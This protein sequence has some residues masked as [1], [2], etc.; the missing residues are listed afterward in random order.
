MYEVRDE[1]R[2]IRF[3]GELL[4]SSSS[5]NK[6][7]AR[8]VEFRLYKTNGG[9]YILS[10]IGVS[11]YYHQQSC[12]V[13]IRNNI[14]PVPAMNLSM[15]LVPCDDCRPDKY[16]DLELFPETP[17]YWAQ[18]FDAGVGAEGVV[19]S[20]KREDEFGAEYLTDVAKKLLVEASKKDDGIYSAFYDEWVD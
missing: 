17:R 1:L 8:W 9:N 15:N 10:R 18:R 4:A 19:E 5:R 11:L 13:V 14:S 20:L 16:R 3:E 6:R 2:T 7:K 12:P